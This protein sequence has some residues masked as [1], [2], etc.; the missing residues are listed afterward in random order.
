MA[1]IQTEKHNIRVYKCSKYSRGACALQRQNPT[2]YFRG[3]GERGEDKSQSYHKLTNY[4]YAQPVGNKKARFGSDTN[5][6]QWDGFLNQWDDR[7]NACFPSFFFFLLSSSFFFF[8][9][10]LL[11]SSFFFFLLLSSLL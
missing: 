4:V 3:E 8:F 1:P 9:L 6:Y 10:L 2:R 11:F 5:I 7:A